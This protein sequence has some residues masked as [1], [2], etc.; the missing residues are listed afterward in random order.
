MPFAIL[1]LGVGDAASIFLIFLSVFFPVVLAWDLYFMG[2][3]WRVLG[4]DGPVVQGFLVVVTIAVLVPQYLALYL[5]AF[6]EQELWGRD[7]SEDH[8]TIS[9][10]S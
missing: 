1:W 2:D 5:Y 9:L 10:R 6:R 7:G 3:N 8:L 4:E